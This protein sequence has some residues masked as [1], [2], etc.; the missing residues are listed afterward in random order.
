MSR[1]NGGKTITKSPA[2][3]MLSGLARNK[4]VTTFALILT[5]ISTILVTIPAIIIGLAVNELLQA[6]GITPVLTLSPL[7]V[8]YVWLII[9][10]GLLYMGLY[11]IVGYVWAIVTLRWERDARQDFFEA[12][13]DYSMTFHDEVDSKRLLAVAM[14]DIS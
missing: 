10:L 11:F 2:R 1:N 12:L 6:D 14:Q 4:G 3:Y 9:G 7:F 5:V 13:Q 8:F